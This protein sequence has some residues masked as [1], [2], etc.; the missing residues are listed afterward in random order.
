MLNPN[1]T[2]K[3]R[4]NIRENLQDQFDEFIEKFN[5]ITRTIRA[6][7]SSNA[8]ERFR[9]NILGHIEPYIKEE[10]EWMV[11]PCESLESY[12]NELLEM[13]DEEVDEA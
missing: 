12:V 11:M 10:H 6:N 2:Q 3:D 8:Y 7:L 13:V 5:D 1:I 4:E 9:Y